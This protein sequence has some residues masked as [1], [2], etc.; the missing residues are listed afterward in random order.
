VSPR[1]PRTQHDVYH[2]R[3]VTFGCLL[4]LLDVAAAYWASDVF[5]DPRA[6]RLFL[7]PALPVAFIAVANWIAGLLPVERCT[8]GL[9]RIVDRKDDRPL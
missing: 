2:G 4:I 6:A 7:L 9:T 8:C 3:R 5:G 1:R